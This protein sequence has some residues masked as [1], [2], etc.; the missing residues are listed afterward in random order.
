[1]ADLRAHRATAVAQGLAANPALAPIGGLQPNG[2]GWA[3]AAITTSA[4]QGLTTAEVSILSTQ[5]VQAFSLGQ[6][7]A[8]TTAQLSVFTTAQKG[9]FTTSLAA[10]L[11]PAD[12]TAIFGS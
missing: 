12:H 8:L 11:T 3:D 1:M 5:E 6:I 10:S 9:A 7:S 2:A 4:I